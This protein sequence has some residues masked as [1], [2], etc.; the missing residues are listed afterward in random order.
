M[1]CGDRTSEPDSSLLLCPVL[2]HKLLSRT[3]CVGS[4]QEGLREGQSGEPISVITPR[5]QDFTHAPT[6][7]VGSQNVSLNP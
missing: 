3:L 1:V 4:L 5:E 2:S 6:L 7:P